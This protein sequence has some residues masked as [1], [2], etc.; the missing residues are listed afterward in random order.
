MLSPPSRALS[1]ALG[2]RIP[3]A[4]VHPHTDVPGATNSANT[5]QTEFIIILSR[6]LLLLCFLS[7]MMQ[8]HVT[9]C[10]SWHPTYHTSPFCL[11]HPQH[12]ISHSVQPS[13]HLSVYSSLLSSCPCLD[14]DPFSSAAWVKALVNLSPH[15]QSFFVPVHVSS[16]ARVMFLQCKW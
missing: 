14:S 13:R 8:S 12:S 4:L 16:A 1:H 5:S 15:L 7:W 2:L 9:S 3:L 10:P 6:Q 11:L